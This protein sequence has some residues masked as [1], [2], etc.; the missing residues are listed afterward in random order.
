[1]EDALVHYLACLVFFV[2]TRVLILVVMEDALV[3]A[4]SDDYL[5]TVEVVLI[6]VVM[7]D[8]LVPGSILLRTGIS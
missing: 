8:A 1:M 2:M 7:E 6:L 4:G 3:H 5:Y